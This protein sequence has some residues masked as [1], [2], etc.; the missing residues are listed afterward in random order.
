MLPAQTKLYA[1]V[2]DTSPYHL[3]E[4]VALVLLSCF[5]LLLVCG[6]GPT[7]LAEHNAHL[8][9]CAIIIE[10]NFV[11]CL[12]HTVHFN[13][14]HA[15]TQFRKVLDADAVARSTIAISDLIFAP[16]ARDTW[17]DLQPCTVQA[18]AKNELQPRPV[19]PTGR[20]CVPCP[21]AAPRVRPDGIDVRRRDVRLDFILVQPGARRGVIDRVEEREQLARAVAVAQKR[22][23]DQDPQRGVR[24]LSAVLA[25]T[26]HVAF[27]VAGIEHAPVERR[28]EEDD[29]AVAAPDEILIN[30]GHRALHAMRVSRAG[31]D[32]PA[33]RNRI[34]AALFVLRRAE[35]RAVVEVSA[36]I[37]VAVPR[38]GFERPF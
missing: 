25:H 27:D 17:R 2:S 18:E 26:R 6:R 13:R 34:N 7:V 32:A 5:W 31:D 20:A 30:C 19:H 23:S 29:E 15:A 11:C 16:P 14:S 35:R 4:Y 10:R 37:P 9:L 1:A 21:P 8:V 28:R 36:P 12:R 24:I 22:V 33:L 38:F 3:C